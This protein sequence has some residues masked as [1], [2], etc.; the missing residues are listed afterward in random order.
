MMSFPRTVARSASSARALCAP[1]PCMWAPLSL[2]C[3][4]SAFLSHGYLSCSALKKL[5]RG[6]PRSP[7]ADIGSTSAHPSSFLPFSGLTS[8]LLPFHEPNMYDINTDIYI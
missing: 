5:Q 4:S 1:A 6:E 7:G 3:L 8:I 2:W